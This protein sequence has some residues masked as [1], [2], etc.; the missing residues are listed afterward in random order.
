[1]KY[2]FILKYNDEFIAVKT[3][4]SYS[5][6]LA[7]NPPAARRDVEVLFTEI[8]QSKGVFAEDE[9]LRSTADKWNIFYKYSK[10][11]SPSENRGIYI[12]CLKNTEEDIPVNGLIEEINYL[13]GLVAAKEKSIIHENYPLLA[14]EILNLRNGV[15]SG[16]VEG[17]WKAPSRYYSSIPGVKNIRIGNGENEI[18]VKITSPKG[19][20]IPEKLEVDGMVFT[21]YTV[22]SKNY[23]SVLDY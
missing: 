16:Y 13:K 14:S 7:P 11:L 12:F 8:L 20:L 22:E 19:S 3:V 17:D 4:R 18:E 5:D 1:M 21:T 6:L 2:T 9:E 10:V 15:G 23:S